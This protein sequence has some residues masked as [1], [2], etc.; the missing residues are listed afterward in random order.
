MRVL[1]FGGT[2]VADAAAI[3]RLVAI[4]RGRQGARTVVVSALAGVTDRL[5]AIAAV[6]EGDEAAARR[7][8][9]DVLARHLTVAATLGEAAAAQLEPML[10]GIGRGAERAVESIGA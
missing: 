2:S 4:V 3:D 7:A 10:R 9:D 8:L 6:A 5:L 1:K